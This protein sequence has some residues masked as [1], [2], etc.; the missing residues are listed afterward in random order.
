MKITRTLSSTGVATFALVLG[1]AA[2]AAAVPVP[3]ENG[4]IVFASGRTGGDAGRELFLLPVP[5]S[6]GGGTLSPAIASVAGQQHRHPAWSPDRTKIVYARVLSPTNTD[7]FV[8]DLT[9]PG[10]TPV[11]ITQSPTVVEDRPAWSPDGSH[12]AWD[13]NAFGASEIIVALP[14][15]GGQTNITNT[16][17]FERGPA[18]SPDSKTIFYET[19][20][21]NDAVAD[22]NVVKRSITLGPPITV[23]AQSLAVAD[24]GISEIQPSVS[25][26]GTHICFGLQSANNVATAEVMVAPLTAVPSGGISISDNDPVADYNCAFSP[27]SFYVA[28]VNGSGTSNARLMMARADST[29][30]P[31]ELSNDPGNNDFDGQ[32]DWAP[33]GRPD[34]PDQSAAT[35]PGVAV[36]I[37]VQC[38][39]TGP[40]Y[41]RST[42]R[43]FVTQQPQHGT[44]QQALAGDPVVYTPNPGFVGTD[45]FVI[46]SF[47]ELGFGSDT[48]TVTVAVG[49][50]AGKPLT[51]SGTEGNDTINGTAGADVISGLGGDDVISGLGGDDIVCGGAGND[52]LSGGPGNDKLVGNAGNDSLNGGSG[53]KDVCK[54][55]PGKKDR[56]RKCEKVRSVP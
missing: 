36:S 25:A 13:S 30:S 22:D 11:N 15:G 46:K 39:D 32:P 49:T 14:N 12:I 27:D 8:L 50:C 4:R 38:N 51:L 44:T 23:G 17:G 1:F 48:G 2:P 53:S 31:I 9:T 18:W 42:V 52:R 54:G 34:C 56:A 29:G 35:G 3:G 28:Y 40:L 19:G 20:D 45:T 47:D 43:E 5:S 7:L 41:E 16:A 26:D 10:A 24:S 6:T 21:R 55:G 37:P 33:D